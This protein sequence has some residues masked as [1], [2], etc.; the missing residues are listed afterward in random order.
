MHKIKNKAEQT[1]KSKKKKKTIKKITATGL[2]PIFLS[3]K[4]LDFPLGCRGIVIKFIQI[5]NCTRFYEDSRR[6]SERSLNIH[7]SPVNFD[8]Q[9]T[10]QFYYDYFV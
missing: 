1:S 5:S 2:E 8:K 9:Y 6:Q 7:V 10:G 4:I 3:A